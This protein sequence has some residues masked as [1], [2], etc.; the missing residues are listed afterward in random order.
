MNRPFTY[1]EGAEAVA[2]TL[3]WLEFPRKEFAALPSEVQQSYRLDA[4]RFLE[5]LR[6]LREMHL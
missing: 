6:E 5:R 2:L 1:E 4:R 3:F